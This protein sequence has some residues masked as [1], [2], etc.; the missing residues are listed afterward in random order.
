[1]DVA[2][3]DDDEPLRVELAVQ[4]RELVR[5]QSTRLAP[6]PSGDAGARA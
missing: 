4:A 5:I 1:M 6:L 3:S 2:S